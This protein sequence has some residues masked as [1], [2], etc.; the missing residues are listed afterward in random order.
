MAFNITPL[1]LKEYN[2]YHYL[3]MQS[4]ENTDKLIACFEKYIKRGYNPNVILEDV[5]E[6]CGLSQ[7]DIEE[8]DVIRLKETVEK[9][10]R[11]YN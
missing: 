7:D 10:Y 4:A 3:I 5:F 1:N 11:R 9:L 6:E 8:P 2:S